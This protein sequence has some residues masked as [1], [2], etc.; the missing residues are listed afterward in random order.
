MNPWFTILLMK[1]RFFVQMSVLCALYSLSLGKRDHFVLRLTLGM[2]AGGLICLL[3]PNGYIFL[4]TGGMLLSAGLVVLCRRVP[5]QDGLYCAACAYATQHFAYAAGE[6]LYQLINVPLPGPDVI[7]PVLVMFD[8]TICAVFYWL[9]ARHLAQG[10]QYCVDVKHSILSAVMLLVVVLLLSLAT[11]DAYAAEQGEK[12]YLIC[13]C[14]AMFSCVFFL[15]MQVSQVKQSQLQEKLTFERQLVRQQREQYELSRETIE[16]INH[17][18]HDLKH[19]VAALRTCVPVDQ[20]ERY[21]NELDRCVRI[22][23]SNLK[24]GSEV[25]DTVLTEKSLYCEAHQITLTC[26]ANGDQLAFLDPVDVYTIFGNALDNA[27]EG[28]SRVDDSEK[29]VISVSVTARSGLVIVQFENYYEGELAF[30]GSLPQ[31]TKEQD[32]S[33]GYGLRSIQYTVEKYGGYMT[34]H[35]E[36]NLFLLRI[37]IPIPD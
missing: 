4:F 10:G 5:L 30:S 9:F 23:D 17:K 34:I 27:I 13:R 19:Q 28:V 37:S 31:T 22:Y 16:L 1:S 25:L 2:T 32:G 33:H 29:R 21:L 18:C 14:Y 35:P 20:Q 6:V 3:L 11:S 7:E 26:I 24:T 15:G 8:A 36:G 12:L